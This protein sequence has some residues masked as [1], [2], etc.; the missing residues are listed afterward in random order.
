MIELD[1]KNYVRGRSEYLS[2]LK[3]IKVEI[4]DCGKFNIVLLKL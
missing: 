3:L 4:F 1:A 2:L